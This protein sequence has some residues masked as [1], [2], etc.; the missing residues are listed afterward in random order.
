MTD[1]TVVGAGV[2]GL[3]CALRLLEEGIG[4]TVRSAD[5][6]RHTVSA[7]AAA[8]WYPS[9][10]PDGDERLL[11]WAGAGFDRLTDQ[12]ER[13][14]PG[15]V[16]RP[17]RMLLRRPAPRPWWADVVPDF[18]VLD[19]AEAPHGCAAE[20]RFTA[21]TVEMRPYVRWLLQRFAEGGGVLDRRPVEN[22]ADLAAL[23]VVNASGLA[24]RT[25][26]DDPAVHPIRG[27]IV[28]VTNPGLEVSVRD[29][30]NPDGPAYV[31]PRSA[32]VVLGGSVEPHQ[33]ETTLDADAA[34]AI[35]DRC[36]ALVPALRRARVLGEAVGL[37][38]GRAGGIRLEAVPG[39]REGATVI[40]NYGHGG[41][42]VTLAWGC[43]EDTLRL[44]G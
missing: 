19:P 17:T 10:V 41:A 44:V 3:T 25:L 32:D 23:V 13:G 5:E 39:P 42:G 12:A 21:P 33:A 27:R 18:R 26:A 22:L 28:L 1:V 37:R 8:V 7:T 4:V 2:I 24:A 29:E 34:G 36:R 6:P 20:W 43:A 38:P 11:R 31:H 35:L 15:A 40:H 9:G 16:M 14:V 30:Q